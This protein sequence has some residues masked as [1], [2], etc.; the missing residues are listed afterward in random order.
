MHQ[1][2]SNTYGRK[3]IANELD[4]K[5]IRDLTLTEKDIRPMFVQVQVLERGQY[6][7][8]TKH[9][10]PE[11]AGTY[12]I[13]SNGAECIMI[14]KKFFFEKANEACLHNLREVETLLPPEEEL[15]ENLQDYV[16]WTA[17]RAKVYDRLV[18]NKIDRTGRRRQ[19]PTQFS[20]QYCFRTG[21]VAR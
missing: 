19:F 7:G 21:H 20:G 5:P 2:L 14:S 9:V 17:Y 3:T 11:Q 13:V 12:S 10:F 16:D 1:E 4:N 8:L 18:K 6:F 15:Q